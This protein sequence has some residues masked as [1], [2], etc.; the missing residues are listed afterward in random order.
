[1][2]ARDEHEGHRAATTLELFF[3]LCFVVS[4]ALAASNLHQEVVEG[5][6]DEGVLAPGRKPWRTN[7]GFTLQ[8]R[9]F[10]TLLSR[11]PPKEPH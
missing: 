10:A 6:M 4:T 11:R 5:H 3:D 2:L 7:R 8:S 9:Q 1:M